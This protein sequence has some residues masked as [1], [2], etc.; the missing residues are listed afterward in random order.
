MMISLSAP[1]K[2][3][4]CGEYLALNGGPAVL[5]AS[6]PRFRLEVRAGTGQHPFHPDSPAGRYLAANAAAF[7]SY[8]LKFIDPYKTGGFGGSTAEF[9]LVRALHQFGAGVMTEHQL[10][11]DVRAA[12][13]EYREL[14]AGAALPPSGA[15]LV[16]QACGLVT[17]FERRTGKIQVFTWPFQNLGF[18]LFKTA[19]KLPTHTHLQD[20]AK[21]E[22]AESLEV[23][24]PACQRVW[25]GLRKSSEGQFLIGLNEVTRH[26]E[27]LGLQSDEVRPRTKALRQVPGI[28]AAKGCGAMGADVVL[29]VFD[30]REIRRHEVLEAG[31]AQDLVPVAT[32]NELGLGLEKDPAQKPK[33]IHP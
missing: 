2:T 9:L 33:E 23:L 3:F 24:E 22:V 30:Q 29:V 26:L 5:I 13:N 27:N 8:D 6:E 20:F 16:G 15:D 7:A 11:L 14:H 19:I 10:D 25:D 31:R 17:A 4:L 28:R 32:E 18:V 1:G 21:A 12:W